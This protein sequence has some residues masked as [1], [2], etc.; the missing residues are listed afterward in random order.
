MRDYCDAFGNYLPQ[1]KH[2]SPNTLDSYLRDVTQYL[3]YLQEQHIKT[4]TAA[5]SDTIT[6][7]VQY[8]QDAQKSNATIMRHI[9][10]VRCFYQYL[11]L[12]GEASCN[13]AKGIKLERAPKKLP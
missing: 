9:A 13:P 8:L 10:S 1:V 12:N 7:Y 11:M 6:A 4:P 2:V 5:S 3:Q